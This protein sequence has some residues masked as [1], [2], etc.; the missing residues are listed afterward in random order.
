[1]S[2][3]NIQIAISDLHTGCQMGLCHPDGARLDEGGTYAPSE[4][5][6]KIYQIWEHVWHH[7]LREIVG[8]QKFDLINNGDSIDGVHH[9]SVTQWS[10]NLKD[11][12]EH[13]ALLLSVPVGLCRKS[14]GDYYHIRGTEAHGGQSGQYEEELAKTL[15]A[16]PNPAG[17]YARYFLRKWL[18]NPNRRFLVHYSHHIAGTSSASY[19][20]T[21][22][23]KEL[24]AAWTDAARWGRQAPDVVVFGHRHRH[25][26]I[27]VPIMFEGKR[28]RARAIVLPGW[29]G[30][31]PL[32]YRLAGSSKITSQFGAVALLL[33]PEGEV[34][35][36]EYVYT[37]E[38]E[39]PDE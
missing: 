30:P 14:G 4:L 24:V 11:Q 16:V 2:N 34:Y 20:S 13:A 17:Q 8:K 19:E 3:A 23:Y 26:D 22:V 21:A 31:T 33:T 12:K 5:Q 15:G 9:N 35:T 10:H 1:M 6:V 18:G 36:R 25:F 37:P 39:P 29:Q 32:V 28:R 38:Q 7:W 27:P